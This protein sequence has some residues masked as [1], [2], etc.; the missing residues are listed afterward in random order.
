MGEIAD[1]IVDGVICQECLQ[2]LDEPTGYPVTC[3]ECAEE[4]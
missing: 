2:P 3:E 1:D 4:E